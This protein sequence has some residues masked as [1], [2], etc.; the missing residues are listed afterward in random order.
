MNFVLNI[1]VISENVIYI[2]LDEKIDKTLRGDQI[3]LIFK[4]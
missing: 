3:S 1:I 2:F 4:R